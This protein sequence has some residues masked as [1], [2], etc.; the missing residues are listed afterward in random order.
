LDIHASEKT[1][2][3]IVPPPTAESMASKM[4]WPL[5]GAVVFRNKS[6]TPRR[7]AFYLRF[8]VF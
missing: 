1:I 6:L 8:E 5:T 7:Y 2:Q 4:E 3:T